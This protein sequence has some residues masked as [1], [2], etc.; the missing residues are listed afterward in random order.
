MAAAAVT[1]YS[2]ACRFPLWKVIPSSLFYAQE[3]HPTYAQSHGKHLFSAKSPS[4]IL[5]KATMCQC[6]F[7]PKML[8]SHGV[9]AS[10]H[11]LKS[12]FVCLSLSEQLTFQRNDSFRTT[13]QHSCSVYIH[14]LNHF[15]HLFISRQIPCQPFFFASVSRESWLKSWLGMKFLKT[16]SDSYSADVIV[17]CF[18]LFLFWCINLL[19]SMNEISDWWSS[20]FVYLL[21]HFDF[22]LIG[23][24]SV[25]YGQYIHVIIAKLTNRITFNKHTFSVHF[26]I[27]PAVFILCWSQYSVFILCWSQ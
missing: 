25:G 14:S 8:I 2:L 5:F 27:L 6:S 4:K 23:A 20:L 17:E 9:Y 3:S 7:P 12:A 22:S 10:L 1:M 24:I 21:Y 19:P 26:W 16:E 15:C 13:N 11:A 18:V